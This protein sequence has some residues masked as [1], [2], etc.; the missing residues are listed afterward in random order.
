V[1]TRVL[2]V[3]DDRAVRSALTLNLGRAGYEVD[4]VG[5]AE[6]ALARLQQAPA[7]LV[8]SDVKMP[9]MDGHALL[10]RLRARWPDLAVVIMTGQGSVS[11]A[12]QAMQAGAA[13]YLIKPVRRDELLLVLE[14]ALRARRLEAEVATLRAELGQ[15]GADDRCIG[16]TPAMRRVLD[17]VDAVAES[18]ALVL[19]TGPTGTGKEVISHALHHRSRRRG[20]PFVGVN[21][22]ALPEG[23]LESELF[24][25]EKGAFTGAVRR[26]AGKFEQAHGGTL[27]LDEIGEI[28]LSTQ[29]RLLRVL[30]SGELQRVGGSE[31]LRVDVRVIA[32]TNRDLAAEVRAGRFREDLY[33]RLQVFHIPLPT[34]RE[35]KEDIPLLVEHFIRKHAP[36]HGRPARG[37]TPEALEAL[38]AAPWPGNVRQLEHV[39][40]RALILCG[41]PELGLLHLPDEVR[42]PTPAAPPAP[43]PPEAA[44]P[45]PSAAPAPAGASLPDQLDAE[46][47]RLIIDALR[48]AGGVQ[49]EAA[50]QLG[51][52]RSNLHYRIRRLQITQVDVIFR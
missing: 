25:H 24:G 42:A 5:S 38:Q 32:A 13:D 14:R 17:L 8:L 7:D 47:R 4:A 33:Y 10:E 30:E 26:H 22:A 9:G 41:G 48:A 27:L 11:A 31:T 15:R 16:D 36:R 3:D 51:V 34:L 43:A 40:E 23:L 12:V 19:V 45:G 52:S 1:A 50:R 2:V 49:A 18:D 39:I 29:V 21:C 35:R 44:P 37:I 6:E 28:P 46:E 20:G